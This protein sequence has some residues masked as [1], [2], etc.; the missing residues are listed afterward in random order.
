[1]GAAPNASVLLAKTEIYGEDIRIEEDYFVEALEWGYNSGAK[2][3]TASLGY[4]RWYGIFEC[5]MTSQG[6]HSEI[7]MEFQQ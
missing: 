6:T 3:A 1:M 4:F 5:F 7:S 2:I